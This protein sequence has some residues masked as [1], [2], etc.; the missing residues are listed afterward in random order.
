MKK[1]LLSTLAAVAAITMASSANAQTTY[2]DDMYVRVDGGYAIGMKNTEQAAVFDAGVGFRMNEYFKADLTAQWRPWGKQEFK[3]DGAKVGKAD[4]W[5]MGAM[6]NVYASYPV[7]DKFSVYAT[8]GVGYS[9]N[10][11]DSFKGV[12]KGKGRSNFAWNVG[13]GV[14]YALTPCVTLD[15]GYR[16]SDL[17]KAKA[18]N[19]ASGA[20]L[21]ENVKYSD[22]KIGMQYYF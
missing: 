14:E 2:F 5:T 8:G 1:Y 22:V 13:A 20:K 19:T 3:E 21:E 17:G 10:K 18:E 7:Y 12:Y 6:A 15:L 4:M 9:Y 11:A 16:F